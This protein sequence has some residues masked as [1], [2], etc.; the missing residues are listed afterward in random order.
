MFDK[1][2]NACEVSSSIATR[3][4]QKLERST[5]KSATPSPVFH[6]MNIPSILYRIRT[7]Y[8]KDG[9]THSSPAFAEKRTIAHNLIKADFMLTFPRI[10]HLQEFSGRSHLKWLRLCNTVSLASLRHK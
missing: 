7:P 3:S 8:R 1:Q 4:T 10:T 9:R 2:T 5:Q 6:S